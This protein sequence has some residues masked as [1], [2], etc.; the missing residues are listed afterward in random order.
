M[1]S[2]VEHVHTVRPSSLLSTYLLVTLLFDAAHARTL[3]LRITNGA[4]HVIAAIS[5]A[6]VAVKA[7]LVV[8]EAQRKRRLLRPEY[9]SYPPEATSGIYG[10]SFFLWLNSLIRLGFGRVLDIDELFSLDRHLQASHL[11]ER[12]S[13]AWRSGGFAFSLYHPPHSASTFP[14]SQS[15]FLPAGL[16]ASRSRQIA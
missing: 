16:P 6:T 12:F 5:T 10:R 9:R 15:P 8:L 1:L 4:D 11:N 14:A 7:V 3:W 13:L 2:Y